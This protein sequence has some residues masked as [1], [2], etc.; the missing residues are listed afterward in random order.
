MRPHCSGNPKT[1]SPFLALRRC[2]TG[3]MANAMTDAMA[4]DTAQ[5]QARTRS[6]R[7]YLDYYSLAEAPFAITPDPDF[8]FFSGSLQQILEKIHYAIDGRM[9]FVLLTGEVGTGK[10]TVC[11]TLLDRLDGKAD[12]VYVVNPSVSGRELL[13]GILDDLN[14]TV[15]P[16]ATKKDLIDRLN[17]RLL[18]NGV[19]RPLVVIIDEAQ[20]MPP[21]T[22]ED[23]RLLSNLETDKHKLIQVILSGQ[24]ELSGLLEKASLRQLRQRIAIHCRLTPLSADET[25]AY[26][27]R[28]LF[29]AGNQGQVRFSRSAIRLIHRRSC[30]IPRLINKICDFALTAGYVT[31]TSTI[32]TPHVRKALAESAV[33]GLDTLGKRF[34]GHSLFGPTAAIAALILLIVSGFGIATWS[35]VA[36]AP[37][38]SM[39]RQET[40]RSTVST[41]ARRTPDMRPLS[42]TM[43]DKIASEIP[44]TD[45]PAADRDTGESLQEMA[46][47]NF[48]STVY[49]LQLGSYRSEEWAERGAAQFAERGIPAQWQRLRGGK[50]YRVF[51]GKFDTLDQANHYKIENG[52]ISAMVINAPFS[53]KVISREPGVR[54]TDLPV[55]LSEMG[56][57]SIMETNVTGDK[58]CHTGVFKSMADASATAGRINGCRRLLAQVV[59]R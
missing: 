35:S 43:K 18:E 52:L 44:V 24:P 19:Q 55:L 40:G 13:S 30:G 42:T 33:P 23:L 8:L 32:G 6:T 3:R 1:E 29:V 22:L 28:R 5:L 15:P 34:V 45:T 59:A 14:E 25:G 47:T 11:R 2:E 41:T 54:D 16:K 39:A 4:N 58:E 9:G 12:T 57:D 38:D 51:T 50:W 17:N 37:G 21:E 53:V 49:A 31:D 48:R 26:I 36:I 56:Y 7:V 27:A 20:T 46:Q 10:T